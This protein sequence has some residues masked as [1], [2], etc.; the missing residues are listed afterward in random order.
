MIETEVKAFLENKPQ[1]PKPLDS[2]SDCP[3]P[4]C[5][6]LFYKALGKNICK[7]KVDNQHH[8]CNQEHTQNR[9]FNRLA[10]SFRSFLDFSKAKRNTAYK[11]RQKQQRDGKN[12]ELLRQ[13][14][15]DD[16]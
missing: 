12:I 10:F 16:E 5:G 4:G 15:N 14:A 1:H 6:F 8:G 7:K 3:S 2:I 13:K 9:F 11:N